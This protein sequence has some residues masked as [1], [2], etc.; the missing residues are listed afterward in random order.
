[1]DLHRLVVQQQCLSGGFEQGG[2]ERRRKGIMATERVEN[3]SEG[4]FW[5]L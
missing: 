1:M 5:Y 2:E 3:F 4:T